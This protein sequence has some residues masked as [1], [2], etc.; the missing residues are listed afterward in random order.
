M[1]DAYS[2]MDA[3]TRA[4]IHDSYIDEQEREY[5]KR[6]ELVNKF[7]DGWG[8]YNKIPLFRNIIDAAVRGA[9]PWDIINRLVEMNT[10]Q[11]EAMKNYVLHH[12]YPQRIE[13]TEI[14]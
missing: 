11:A 13:I 3:D 8:R 12:A 14:K 7:T 10:E 6:A 4:A 2:N 1:N 5:Q 9:D